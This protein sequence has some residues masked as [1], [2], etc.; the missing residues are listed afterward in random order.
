MNKN[1]ND[2]DIN[3]TDDQDNEDLLEDINDSEVG[4]GYSIGEIVAEDYGEDDEQLVDNVDLNK[5][6]P[7]TN[8]DPDY[9]PPEDEEWPLDWGDDDSDDDDDYDDYF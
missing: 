6:D 9:V 8:F 3:I 4:E 1:D 7:A 2:D 5:I